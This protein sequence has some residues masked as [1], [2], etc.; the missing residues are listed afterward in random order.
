MAAAKVAPVADAVDPVAVVVDDH[1][2]AADLNN[3]IPNRVLK[4]VKPALGQFYC[5]GAG[6]LS[7]PAALPGTRA[8]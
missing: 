1:V 5:P 2:P 6:F 7:V 3:R 8:S 4:Q